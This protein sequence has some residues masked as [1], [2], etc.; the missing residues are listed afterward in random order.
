MELQ[1]TMDARKWYRRNHYP[2]NTGAG[3][4]NEGISIE[5]AVVPQAG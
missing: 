2:E 1:S 5:F 4:S 3:N